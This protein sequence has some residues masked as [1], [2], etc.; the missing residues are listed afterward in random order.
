MHMPTGQGDAVDAHNVLFLKHWDRIGAGMLYA[1]TSAAPRAIL[2]ARA[3]EHNVL[4][5]GEC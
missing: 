2:L 1:A 5:C 3:F 4:A